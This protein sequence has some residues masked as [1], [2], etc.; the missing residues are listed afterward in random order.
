MIRFVALK[1]VV[2]G[3]LAFYTGLHA[4]PCRAGAY[5]SLGPNWNNFVFE[6][7]EYEETP[8]YYGY[9]GRGSFGYSIGQILDLGLYGHYAPGRLNAATSTQ[10]GAQFY[11]LGAET[12]LRLANA[13]YVGIRGG[14]ASYRLSKA[15]EEAEV[16]GTW[17]GSMIQGS[18]G[19]ILPVG[20]TPAAWQT[21]L[22]LGQA[23]LKS[24]DDPTL[25]ARTLTQISLTLAFVY[26]VKQSTAVD[27]AILNKWIN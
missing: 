5:G 18:V 25:K 24:A 14:P 6:P 19:L 11:H 27:T 22:D 23:T 3:G 9:G 4:S 13:V 12:A 2:F 7:L 10:T 1:W 20:K 15:Y 17:T 26:N 16:L 8:N 21:T